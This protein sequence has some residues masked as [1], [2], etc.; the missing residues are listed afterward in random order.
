MLIVCPHC[1]TSYRIE[2]PAL[3]PQGRS[4][5]CLRCRTVW[6]A[7][8]AA[9][10]ETPPGLR[11]IEPAAAVTG[12]L[13]ASAGHELA[14]EMASDLREAP[15]AGEIEPAAPAEPFGGIAAPQADQNLDSLVEDLAA[16][17]P[18]PDEESKVDAVAEPAAAEIADIAEAPSIVPPPI[19]PEVTPP[20]PETEKAE[21]IES[22]AARRTRLAERRRN[23]AMSRPGLPLTILALIAVSAM[24][25]LWRTNIVRMAPQTASLYSAI[26]LQ[27]NLRGLAFE[28]VKTSREMHDGVPVLV[29]EGNIVSVA[30]RPVEVPRLR[31]AMHN[32]GGAEVY[33]WTTLPSRSI[34]AP[35][36][37]L[38]FR[39][40]LASPPADGKDVLVR[41][42][43]RRDAMAGMK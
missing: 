41:F 35:G 1:A 25:M 22:F 13:I 34:L 11:I 19:P 32:A 21:D 28:K 39:S 36:E 33:S 27:V 26:G 31:F 3:G 5:R 15:A 8:A 30:Q 6:F 14:S 17:M 42:F 20:L 4:V 2:A 38:A 18:G 10:V 43:S 9:P 29:I 12:P 37:E 16:Q 24:L 23:A 40:R 7:A